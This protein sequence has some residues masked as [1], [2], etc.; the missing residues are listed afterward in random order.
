MKMKSIV[1]SREKT[2]YV[3]FA[4]SLSVSLSFP[5]SQNPQIK[6][7]KERERKKELTFPPLRFLAFLF[8]PPVIK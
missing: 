5:R 8:F 3:R 2:I 4:L 7:E 6:F 1:L